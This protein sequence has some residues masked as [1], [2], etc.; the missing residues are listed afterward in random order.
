MARGEARPEAGGRPPSAARGVAAGPL[1]DVATQVH[2]HPGAVL[3]WVGM[4]GI[5]MPVHFDAGNGD[6]QRANARVGVFVLEATGVEALKNGTKIV[7]FD[8]AH[9]AQVLNV[10]EACAGLKSLMTFVSIGAA[11][12]TSTSTWSSL[13]LITLSSIDLGRRLATDRR[14]ATDQHPIAPSTRLWRELRCQLRHGL[15]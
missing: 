10:E 3:D 13:L 4:D 1:P 8:A 14:M 9:K 11:M 2:S 15:R 6:V 12:V 7:F 5:E